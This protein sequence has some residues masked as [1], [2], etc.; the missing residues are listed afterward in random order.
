MG[1]ASGSAGPVV[2]FRSKEGM[3]F[4]PR[5][6]PSN[7]QTPAQMAVRNSLTKAA[8]GYKALSP[9]LLSAWEQYAQDFTVHEPSTGKNRK[10]TGNAVYVQLATV[11][12]RFSPRGTF[13]STPPATAFEGDAIDVTATAATGK[14]TFTASA[15]NSADVV[16][17]FFLQRLPSFA[18]KPSKGGYRSKGSFAFVSGT[19]TFDVNVTSGLYAAG[20]RFVNTATGQTTPIQYLPVQQVTLSLSQGDKQKKAA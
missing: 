19:L 20:Y 18:R 6:T 11:F 12:F 2:F 8:R 4:G 3:V 14:I 16:T 5:V 10:R 9:T 7:P 1:G 17:E 13:P 15:A